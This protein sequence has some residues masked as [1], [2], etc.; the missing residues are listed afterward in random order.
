MFF[1]K[2]WTN[3]RTI[4]HE[5][6]IES[7]QIQFHIYFFLFTCLQHSFPF[8]MWPFTPFGPFSSVK[9]LNFRQKLPIRTARYTYFKSRHPEIT[10]NPYYILFLEGNQKSV[11]SWNITCHFSFLVFTW[12]ESQLNSVNSVNSVKL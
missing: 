3:L 8:F 6:N 12:S 5:G 11:S 10:K 4:T 1:Y 9:C 2:E 7:R